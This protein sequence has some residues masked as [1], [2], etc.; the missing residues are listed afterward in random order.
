[1]SG[2]TTLLVKDIRPPDSPV[3]SHAELYEEIMKRANAVRVFVGLLSLCASA[4]AEDSS[5][6]VVKFGMHYVDPKSDN[7]TLADGAFRAHIGSDAQPTIAAEYFFNG[8]WSIEALAALPFEHDVKLD[9]PSTGYYGVKV[10]TVRQLPP[11]VSLQYHFNQDGAISPFVGLGFN[12][13]WF[14][15]EHTR[16]P[17]DAASLDL[18]N[19]FG[20]AAHVG[21][22]IKLDERW[23]LSLDARWIDIDTDTKLNGARIGTVHIDPFVYGFAFGYRF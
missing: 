19:A 1:L 22:D 17:L 14:L 11:T 8:N 2:S 18:E 13:T 3:S 20:P 5:D 4:H 10:A 21:V 6:W 16:G 7:G 23:L 12:Y 15:S 9:S